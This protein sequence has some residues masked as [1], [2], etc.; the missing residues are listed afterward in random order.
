MSRPSFSILPLL[1]CTSATSAQTTSVSLIPNNPS[2][3]A[4]AVVPSPWTGSSGELGF[5]SARGNSTAEN[6]NGRLKVKYN[7]GDWIHSLDLFAN[8]SSSNY[9]ETREDGDISRYRQTT[10]ERYTGAAG[11][12]LQLGEFRQLIA[13]GRYE[14]DRFA[15]YDRLTTFGIGYGTRLINQNRFSLDTQIGPGVRRAHNAYL[16]RTEVGPIGRGLLDLKYRISENTDLINN[17]LVEVGSYNNYIQNDLG[18][19]VAMNQR[20]ALKAAWQLR[21]NTEVN[22]DN[23][24]TDTLTTVNL[25]YTFK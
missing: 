24:K 12:A 10:A 18:V 2:D 14:R 20:F 9:T 6:L 5:S 21:H 25:V 16:A 4:A 7:E 11:S 3:P 19:Q 15:T 8:R 22:G 1:L 13:T 17:L 23:K